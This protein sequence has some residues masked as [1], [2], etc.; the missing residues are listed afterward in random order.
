VKRIDVANVDGAWLEV[1]EPW[2][3]PVDVASDLYG[4]VDDL[5]ANDPSVGT[6]YTMQGRTCARY[7]QWAVEKWHCPGVVDDTPPGE[8][9]MKVLLALAEDVSEAMDPTGLV[10]A[11][12]T[13]PETPSPE[14]TEP[15]ED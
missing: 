5:H 13:T 11:S 10:A 2:T 15:A 1:R 14:S 9:P 6:I 4:I 12:S 7:A 8:L 3:C